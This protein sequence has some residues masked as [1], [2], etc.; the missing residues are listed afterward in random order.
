MAFC[1][2]SEAK[3]MDIKMNKKQVYVM[4][5]NGFE[6]IEALTVVDILRRGEVAVS[7]VSITEEKMVTSSHGILVQADL[8]FSEMKEEETEMIV[9]PGGMPG[10]VNLKEKQ[11]LMDMILRRH[12]KRQLIS[13]ICAAP[14]LIFGELGILEG[15]NA[16]CYP[17]ME[18]HMR[19]ANYQKE[20]KA[21]QDGHIITGCGMGGAIPFG[22]KILEAL[23]GKEIAEKVKESIVY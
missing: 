10:T 22:L 18:E 11:E 19:G 21:V 5:A 16:I 3:G 20:E 14:A 1:A 2:L 6:E 8:T 15:R 12:E 7:T 9:L 23:K 13:A 4:L 17:S